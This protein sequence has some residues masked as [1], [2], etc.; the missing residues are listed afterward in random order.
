MPTAFSYTRVSTGRQASD[1]GGLERQSDDAQL[2]CE[3]NGYALDTDLDLSDAGASA[4]KGD[5]LEGA[6]G[7]FLQMARDG[8]LP[9]ESVLLVEAIDRLSRLEALD[10]L[11]DVCGALIRSGVA[12]HTL[13][14]D[15]TYSRQTLAED[16]TK[17]I[18]LVVKAQAAHDYSRRLSRRIVKSWEQTVE[19]QRQGVVVRGNHS[20]FWIDYDAASNSFSINKEGAPSSRV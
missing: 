17:L 11:M 18:V 2:W 3:R 9:K 8:R 5:H 7:R 16:G 14:D 15:Q 12:I 10:G 13:E 20:P 19:K 1:G 4:F 6:L